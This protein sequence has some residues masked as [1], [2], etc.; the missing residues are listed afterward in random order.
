MKCKKIPQIISFTCD[1]LQ[2]NST[3]N[4]LRDAKMVELIKGH[5]YMIRCNPNDR[6]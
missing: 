4:E 2:K 5:A 3:E 1:E 6:S